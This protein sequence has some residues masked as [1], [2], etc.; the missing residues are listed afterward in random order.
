MAHTE[1]E[2]ELEGH[3]VTTQELVAEAT[4]LLEL[5]R[6]HAQALRP[7]GIELRNITELD[8]VK[9]LLV[10]EHS[11]IELKPVKVLPLTK[12]MEKVMD[13]AYAWRAM[14]IRRADRAYA[15]DRMLRLRFHRRFELQRLPERLYEEIHILLHLARHDAKRLA[16]VGVTEVFLNQGE[17][18]LY[19]LQGH[20]P[21]DRKAKE[22]YE[23]KKR[24]HRYGPP[25]TPPPEP[26]RL[27]DVTDSARNL[28]V[29]KGRVLL[30]MRDL[31]A[32]GQVA[33][34]LP[35]E[36][37]ERKAE[38]IRRDFII[39]LRLHEDE[40]DLI[41]LGRPSTGK[42]EAAAPAPTKP[43]TPE[44]AP[45]PAKPSP[46]PSPRGPNEQGPRPTAERNVL[47]ME[48]VTSKPG[49]PNPPPPTDPF[50]KPPPRA[51]GLVRP[52]PTHGTKTPGGS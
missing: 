27:P 29:L 6:A 15:D 21:P 33:H 2:L 41:T 20:A 16:P 18:L 47:T 1:K 17:D 4:R 25:P 48:E 39:R 28:S 12:E 44:P 14:M 7:E 37:E 31:S 45:A 36:K 38:S 43:A 23:Q 50:K 26:P 22:E 52:S 46:I 5:A 42:V 40:E 13:R 51:V 19:E 3:L 35:K 8:Q 10:K 32:A 9:E 30:L 11:R 49:G 24:T 34:C